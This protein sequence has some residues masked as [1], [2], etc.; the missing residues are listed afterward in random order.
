M[1]KFGVKQKQKLKQKLV[2]SPV[3]SCR[4]DYEQATHW[5]QYWIGQATQYAR[6][7]GV[8]VHDLYGAEDNKKNF[9]STVQV[10]NY[11]FGVGHGNSLVFTGQNSEYLINASS[12]ADKKLVNGKHGSFLSCQFGKASIWLGMKSFHGYTVDFTFTTS[13]Y[14]NGYA[15]LFFEPHIEYDKE[16][17]AGATCRQAWLQSDYIWRVKLAESN[18]YPEYVQRYLLEDYEGRHFRGDW[19]SKPIFDETPEP[20]PEPE[21]EQSWY[22]KS[23]VIPDFIK[24]WLG[25]KL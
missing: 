10:S 23:R 18:N 14:P 7:L 17:L 22:C 3:V 5:G 6:D 12:S 24:K 25:C 20:D 21:P 16:I 13:N 15:A 19:N 9:N 8:T 11:I 1:L 4:P 2:K